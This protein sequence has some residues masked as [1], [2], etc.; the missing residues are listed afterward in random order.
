MK[1]LIYDTEI[2]SY[3]ENNDNKEYL[4]GEELIYICIIYI[5]HIKGIVKKAKFYNS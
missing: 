4:F 2:S 1:T 5:E 3:C